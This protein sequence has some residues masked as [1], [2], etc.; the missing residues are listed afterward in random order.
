MFY[1]TVLTNIILNKH[2]GVTC[3]SLYIYE[4]FI[5]TLLAQLLLKMCVINMSYYP[6]AIRVN[7]FT[8]M[9]CTVRFITSIVALQI[10][11][12]RFPC[13]PWCSAWKMLAPNL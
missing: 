13:I 6:I 12:M 1:A 8:F 11:V 3:L 10:V 2:G 5:N 7:R 9:R 4:V